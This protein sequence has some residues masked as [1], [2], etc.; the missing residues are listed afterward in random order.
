M[1]YGRRASLFILVAITMAGLL[2]PAS[3]GGSVR[4]GIII[5]FV[6]AH[7]AIF[8]DSR[9]LPSCERNLDCM[10]WLATGCTTSDAQ[11]GAALWTSIADVRDLAGSTIREFRSSQLYGPN[12][13][14]LT[15]EFWSA[16]CGSVGSSVVVGLGHRQHVRV[17]AGASWMTISWANTGGWTMFGASMISWSLGS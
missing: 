12:G 11:P 10:A 8:E 4:S 17:P 7:S 16:Y 9:S 2:P 5:G 13:G 15:L 6:D 14:P 3:A 1:R